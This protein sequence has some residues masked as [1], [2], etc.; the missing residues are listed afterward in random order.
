MTKA[1]FN[2]TLHTLNHL[3]QNCHCAKVFNT[4]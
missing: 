2:G 3:K 1:G 4:Q